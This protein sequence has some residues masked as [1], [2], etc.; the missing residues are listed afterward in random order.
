[1]K[2][3]VVDDE[4]PARARLR[5]LVSEITGAE[6]VEEAASGLQALEL[7]QTLEPAVVLLDIRMP[8]MDGIEVARHLSRLP[9]PPA[10]VFTTAYEA[11]ALAAFEVH[12]IDYLLKPIRKERL[13]EALARARQMK[14]GKAD[15]AIVALG[16]AR[17]H[18]SAVQ[19]GR[20]RLVAV[21]EVRYFLADQKYVTAGFPGGELLLEEPLR[22]LEE[23]LGS[24]FL[25]IHR[26]ALVGLSHIEALERDSDGLHRVRLRDV[27][28]TPAVSRRLLGTVKAR[29]RNG[30]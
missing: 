21:A 16:G 2:V 14:P 4:P 24:R 27:P 10:V 22:Q 7:A 15:E 3:L 1:M 19:Q 6:V 13:A 9:R 5:A 30:R 12:A 25:R 8:W 23:E 28:V 20:L 26:N 18:V 17:T 29:L 11:H